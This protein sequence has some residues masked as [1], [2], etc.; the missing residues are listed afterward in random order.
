MPSARTPHV[1]HYLPAIRLS[2]GGVVR[3]VLDLCAVTALR[4]HRVT[5]ATFDASDA[6]P[7]LSVLALP[8]KP[9]SGGLLPA[10]ALGAAHAELAEASFL[11]L[12]GP[13]DPAHVQLARAARMAG[14]PYGVTAHGM[15]DAWS[16]AQKPLK[17]R[18]FLAMFGRRVLQG[19]AWLHCTAEGEAEQV[20]RLLPKARVVVAPLVFDT[21]PFLGLPAPLPPLE[22]PRVLFLSRIHPKKGLEKLIEAC[23]LLQQRGRPVALGIA[24]TGEPAYVERLA[25]E[26]ALRKVDAEFIGMVSGEEKV[27]VLR[28]A[29]VFALPTS[30][31]NF[32]LALVEAMACGTPVITT[33]GVDI[34]PELKAA[35]A[36]I[37]E[38]GASPSEWADAIGAMLA[39]ADRAELGV[40]GRAWVLDALAPAKVVGMYE[41]LYGV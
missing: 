32:G 2:D 33:K 40:R 29:D 9:L 38:V 19:A 6:P 39:R 22:M 21:R 5:L 27:R 25:A 11:H 17:K 28:S 36:E 12:H 4:G 37:L 16:M 15:L 7:D 24:G 23:I 8:G 13:W 10:A 14:V 18:I 34:W 26:V 31:E 35:G 1:I 30:Q 41:A 3:A 20:R